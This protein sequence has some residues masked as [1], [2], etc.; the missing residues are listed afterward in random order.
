MLYLM[1]YDYQNHGSLGSYQAQIIGVRSS[2][3][4]L[5]QYADSVQK[6]FNENSDI[7]NIVFFKSH[8]INIEEKGDTIDYSCSVKVLLKKNDVQFDFLKTIENL[9]NQ[10]IVIDNNSEI[11]L[12]KNFKINIIGDDLLEITITKG[13]ISIN[14]FDKGLNKKYAVSCHLKLTDSDDSKNEAY[15]NSILKT[16]DINNA[17]YPKA[18]LSRLTILFISLFSIAVVI[19]IAIFS[20]LLYTQKLCFSYRSINPTNHW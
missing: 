6:D 14:R 1:D 7:F 11:N 16:I 12:A 2:D 19:L 9:V 20:Y 17:H 4:D 10:N 8:E 13:P 3:N 18:K 5:I 15:K